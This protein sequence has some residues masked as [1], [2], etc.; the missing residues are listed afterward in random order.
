MRSIVD[1]AAVLNQS[2]PDTGG[3]I[4]G[5][6]GHGLWQIYRHFPSPGEYDW[7]LLF[8]V[9]MILTRLLFLPYVLKV[10]G[11]DVERVRKGD[12]TE[13]A[14]HPF[15]SI[16]WDSLGIWILVWLFHTDAGGT[17]L[18]GRT[19]FGDPLSDTNLHT[20]S[21]F[22]WPVVTILPVIVAGI[23]EHK[24]KN[25]TPNA[26][27]RR[28]LYVDGGAMSFFFVALIILAAQI[29]YWYWSNATIILFWAYF[30][31]VILTEAIRVTAIYILLRR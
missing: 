8:L 26:Q 11:K 20:I 19:C 10:L 24:W 15:A 6:I 3:G 17:F 4:S 14:D 22:C 16:F 21:V 13:D 25:T 12:R 27:A 31:A 18:A 9:L 28:F 7:F 29:L 2:T 30:F 5:F 23:A 1:M